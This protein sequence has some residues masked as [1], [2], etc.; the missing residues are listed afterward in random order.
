MATG[1]A[2]TT[3][4]NK[5]LDHLRGGTAWTQPAGIYAKLHTGDPGAAGTANPS[6]VTTRVVITHAAASGGSTTSNGTA[7]SWSMTASETIAYV[8]FWD[9]STAGNFLWS[10]QC[11][12]SKGVVSGDTVTLTT[13]TLALA[14]V[15]A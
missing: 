3:L 1:L 14:P 12:A 15:A 4:A 11:T 9:A 10:A 8:S 13:N 6:A 7:P 5:I 2:A